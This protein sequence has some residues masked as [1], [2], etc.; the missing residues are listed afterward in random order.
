MCFLISDTLL[1][2]DRGKKL[3]IGNND[4]II[5]NKN[6]SNIKKSLPIDDDK[7]NKHHHCHGSALSNDIR[8]DYDDDEQDEALASYATQIERLQEFKEALFDSCQDILIDKELIV[9][10]LC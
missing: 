9:I 1:Y 7:E 8:N 4:E 10:K 6:R 5:S 3:R 2:A